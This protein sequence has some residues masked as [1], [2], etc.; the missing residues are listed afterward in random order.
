MEAIGC[1]RRENR[2]FLIVISLFYRD[3]SCSHTFLAFWGPTK[4]IVSTLSSTSE[5]WRGGALFFGGRLAQERREFQKVTLSNLFYLSLE[6]GR[7]KVNMCVDFSNET[8]RFFVFL[9]RNRRVM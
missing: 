3:N 5:G 2:W 6:V 8:K 9:I 4:N 1:L 7:E